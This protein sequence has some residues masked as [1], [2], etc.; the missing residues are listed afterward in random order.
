M[1]QN[2]IIDIDA[3]LDDYEAGL[4]TQAATKQ[5]SQQSAADLDAQML[6]SQGYV[7][8]EVNYN[9]SPFS[10]VR[11][12]LTKKKEKDAAVKRGILADDPYF[13]ENY[14]PDADAQTRAEYTG[15]DFTGGAEGDVIRQISLLPSDVGSD[16]NSITR[17]IQKN[18]AKDHN[19]PR[20]YDYNVRVEPNTNELIF[21]DPL[22]K[23]QPTIINPPGIDK[24]I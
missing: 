5:A 9:P 20:T 14:L 7:E 3:I 6:S 24:G 13:V 8:P 10:S 2:D 18:Y 22:N 23:N 4:L 12:Y 17:V 11:D 15:V 1:A 16:L 21:N 19:I